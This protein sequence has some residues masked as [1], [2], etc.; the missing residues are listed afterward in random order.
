MLPQERFA[1]VW[2]AALALVFGAYFIA[3]ALV[4]AA[5]ETATELGRITL[6]GAAL[7]LL[8]LVVGVDRLV[9]HFR[10]DED[11]P[12]ITDERDLLVKQHATSAAY[13][14][15]IS[16]MIVVGCVMPFES[17]G[18][19]IVHAALFA[20]VLAEVVHHGLILIAYRRGLR[21]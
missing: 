17:G 13:Y 8:A 1:Y 7:V 15:L 20:I 3:V 10:A 16:C 4:P 9:A 2:L 5:H 12:V 11:E 18:W 19:D 21:A 6:L 14:V